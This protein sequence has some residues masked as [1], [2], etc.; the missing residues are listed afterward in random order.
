MNALKRYHADHGQYP[1]TLD[2]LTPHYLQEIPPPTWGLR[3]WY[4]SPNATSFQIG[5]DESKYTGDG[6]SHW[7]RYLGDKHGWQTGD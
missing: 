3:T 7:F 4:Y 6:N 1:A 2:D 5:V